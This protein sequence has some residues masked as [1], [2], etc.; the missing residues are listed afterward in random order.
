MRKA[1]WILTFDDG[2]LPSDITA[3]RQGQDERLLA[4]IKSIIE[5]LANHL[6]E[7]VPAV[8]FLRGPGFPWKKGKKPPK[9]LFR[10]GVKIILEAGHH[11]AIHCYSH[12]PDLWWNWWLHGDKIHRDLDS[13][14]SFFSG[15]VPDA[16]RVFRPPYG[17]GG[18]AGAAWAV[19]NNVR[20]RRWDIDTDDWLHHPDVG[21]FLRR[22]VRKNQAGA[23]L[24]HI[25]NS[26]PLKMWIHTVW[27]G[28]NDFLLHVS[29]R[30]AQNLPKILDSIVQVT[31][32]QNHEPRF[33]VPDTY[34]RP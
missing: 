31:R 25:R 17:Q 27:P 33:V 32:K 8:F 30:T 14:V 20:H 9:K 21:I 10:Q 3:Y 6:P 29:V 18:L 5:T 7:P 26:L 23:H 19:E 15:M 12:D 28:A 13:C 22:F 11:P 16:M 34:L 2:P 4:P 24:K 1:E